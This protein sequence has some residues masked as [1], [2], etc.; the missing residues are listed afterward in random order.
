[1]RVRRRV[2]VASSSPPAW[3]HQHPS[4]ADLWG[5]C[6]GNGIPNPWQPG[7][8][9]TRRHAISLLHS[10]DIWAAAGSLSV[11]VPVRRRSRTTQ[12][13]PLYP[14]LV[15]VKMSSI[16]GKLGV[17][18]NWVLVT[19]GLLPASQPA[20]PAVCE[21]VMLQLEVASL[22]FFEPLLKELLG[23]N[24][25]SVAQLSPAGRLTFWVS[26]KHHKLQIG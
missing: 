23:E 25:D 19:L 1:M 21:V 5:M 16:S 2:C 3:V 10:P 8:P 6:R 14:W 24:G 11:P 20:C 18:F 7:H 9:G 26:L 22:E 15:F 17:Y 12:R 13:W 4:T